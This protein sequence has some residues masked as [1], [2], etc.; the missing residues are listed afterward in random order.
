MKTSSFA[1]ALYLLAPVVSAQDI[2]NNPS[3][4]AASQE[5][6]TIVANRRT[7]YS[8]AL[9]Q[10]A[11]EDEHS[12]IIGRR[13][14]GR[15]TSREKKKKRMF[16]TSSDDVAPPFT[17]PTP[18]DICVQELQA[19]TIRGESTPIVGKTG[20]NFEFA[21]CSND[22]TL[23]VTNINPACTGILSTPYACSSFATDFPPEYDTYLSCLAT[24]EA[25]P[26]IIGTWWF[27][28]DVNFGSFAFED[29]AVVAAI[30][31][32]DPSSR[33]KFEL[34]EQRLLGMPLGEFNEVFIL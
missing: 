16:S 25:G 32:T 1:A 18:K 9:L 3:S 23:P 10:Q 11:D 15:S 27:N 34:W 12:M 20:L 6:S 5:E 24:K 31:S 29:G 17:N 14:L 4:S 26:V 30:D 22:G 28:R 13:G 21:Q 19:Y 33:T 8:S 2:V 7:S